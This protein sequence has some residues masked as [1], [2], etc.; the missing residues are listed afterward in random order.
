MD[1]RTANTK[2][3]QA[4]TE[5]KELLSSYIGKTCGI[6]DDETDDKII[7]Q[8]ISKLQTTLFAL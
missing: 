5:K 7:L 8:N 3:E 4:I 1:K 6:E 2:K